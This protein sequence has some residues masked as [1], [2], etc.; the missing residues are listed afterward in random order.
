MT[1]RPRW[2]P[3]DAI[4][5]A[6]DKAQKRGFGTLRAKHV[7]LSCRLLSASA[8]VVV[9]VVVV[10]SSSSSSSSGVVVVVVL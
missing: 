9:V 10:I 4:V 1:V 6:F 8:V 5:Q 3:L 2:H 7:W